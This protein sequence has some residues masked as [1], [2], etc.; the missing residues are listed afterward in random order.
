MERR[1]GQKQTDHRG[2]RAHLAGDGR[3]W[4]PFGEHDGALLRLEPSALVVAQRGRASGRVD[5]PNHDRKRLLVAPLAL[6]K[7]SNRFF[8]GCIASKMKTAEPFHTDDP[9]CDQE[10]GCSSKRIGREQHLLAERDQAQ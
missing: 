9:A 5:V 1:I 7:K 3:A 4:M 2:F 10:V 8:V 6:P